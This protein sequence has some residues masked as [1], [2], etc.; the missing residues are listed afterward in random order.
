MTVIVEEETEPVEDS[1]E[2]NYIS[3]GKPEFLQFMSE[4]KE[5]LHDIVQ[6][7]L[8]IAMKKEFDS[9]ILKIYLE[10]N[11]KISN[12]IKLSKLP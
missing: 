9:C 10:N 11:L 8:S 3:A 1:F 2:D 6:T 12:L 5:F 7:K 4:S